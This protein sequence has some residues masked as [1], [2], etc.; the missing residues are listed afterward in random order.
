M[1]QFSYGTLSPVTH[2]TARKF[3]ALPA[4]SAMRPPQFDAFSTGHFLLS[5]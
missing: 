1:P 5:K 2:F 3:V 4:A